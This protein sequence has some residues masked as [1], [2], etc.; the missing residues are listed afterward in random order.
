MSNHA[1]APTFLLYYESLE[2]TSEIIPKPSETSK[3]STL[4]R[5]LKR[6]IPHST[7]KVKHIKFAQFGYKASC[8]VMIDL[9][10]TRLSLLPQ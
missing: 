3:P 8:E 4:L 1:I 5:C 9:P 10:H 7:F 2:S 6:A